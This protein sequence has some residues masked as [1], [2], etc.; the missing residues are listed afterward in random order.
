[1]SKL[2]GVNVFVSA[3][4]HGYASPLLNV[5]AKRVDNIDD[6]HVVLFAGGE[7][8]N[9]QLYKHAVADRTYYNPRRDYEELRDF[10]KARER[11]LPMLGVCR[12]MQLLTA[13]A[14]GYLVQHVT[15]HA[16]RRHSVVT[17]TGEEIEVNS[18]HHQM[19]F[20]NSV[21]DVIKMAWTFDHSHCY[22]GDDGDGNIVDLKK[23]FGDDRVLE[24]E[25]VAYPSLN[26]FA[27]QWHPEMLNPVEDGHQFF[28]QNAIKLIEGKLF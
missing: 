24:L 6:A 14:G 2:S 16:G 20:P 21:A 13:L 10:D 23:K 19:C 12:G 1:M 27:V 4:Y 5:G 11:G 26:A 17:N 22:I 15:N 7:D 25:S 18:L 28:V 8:I 9:P 3:G